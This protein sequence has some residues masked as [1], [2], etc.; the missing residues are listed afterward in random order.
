MA[1]QVPQLSSPNANVAIEPAVQQNQGLAPALSSLAGIA[2][3]YKRQKQ[4]DIATANYEVQR[5]AFQGQQALAGSGIPE[6]QLSDKSTKLLGGV[7]EAQKAIALAR[8]SGQIS[9]DRAHTL[10]E[11]ELRKQIAR[12]PALT[13]E[14]IAAAE[15]TGLRPVGAGK[16][17]ADQYLASLAADTS[18]Q[19]AGEV[20]AKKDYI[21]STF[22]TLTA[23]GFSVLATRIKEVAADQ[24]L[25]KGAEF[26][27]VLLDELGDSI[28]SSENLTALSTDIKNRRTVSDARSRATAEDFAATVPKNMVVRTLSSLDTIGSPEAK[29]AANDVSAYIAGEI[30]S[31]PDTTIQAVLPVWEQIKSGVLSELD[32]KL[33]GV[34]DTATRAAI[35]APTER[36]VEYMDGMFTGKVA[37]QTAEALMQ[38]AESSVILSMTPE[39]R[40]TFAEYK[41]IYK[42]LGVQYEFKDIATIINLKNGLADTTRDTK[43]LIGDA[44]QPVTLVVGSENER[45][46]VQTTASAALA[47]TMDIRMS[48]GQWEK[49]APVQKTA[50]VQE[51][52]GTILQ[53]LA[54]AKSGAE[55]NDLVNLATN[56]TVLSAEA[57]GGKR[58]PQA[59][60]DQITGGISEHVS[61]LAKQIFT[62]I[63]ENEITVDSNGRFVAKPSSRDVTLTQKR[64]K[65]ALFTSYNNYLD[66]LDKIS[67]QG[68]GQAQSI[69]FIQQQIKTLDS[70][71]SDKLT[72]TK[73]VS[74]SGYGVEEV[75]EKQIKNSSLYK[76]LKNQRDTYEQ[77]LGGSTDE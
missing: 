62:E 28:S 75:T 57:T 35:T 47:S 19:A 31:L 71:L 17:E 55:I 34:T 26:A 45:R 22:S 12:S 43:T 16:R 42:D 38:T 10:A 58:L 13:E 70:M 61:K 20:Q 3:D 14:F 54:V 8:G 41:K 32:T 21:N 59:E 1:V 63:P 2:I 7:E 46:T 29:Q 60:I 53:Q 76:Q 33:V 77:L 69:E 30:D 64:R 65:A 66:A 5:A 51:T 40:N 74:S 52:R 49:L 73:K 44:T 11:I 9:A 25:D 4:I 37:G 39:D 68:E 23:G 48:P 24:G 6:Y 15:K 50:A 67:T 27:K 18:T 72:R 36:A 56:L